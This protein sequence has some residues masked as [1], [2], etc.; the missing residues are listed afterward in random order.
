M[1]AAALVGADGIQ[2]WRGAVDWPAFD[3]GDAMVVAGDGVAKLVLYP[4]APGT[5]PDWRLINRVIYAR[6]A[7]EGTPP[8]GREHWSRP[9][10]PRRSVTWRRAWRCHS[11]MSGP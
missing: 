6:V 2:M 1:E 9:G 8:P 7:E 5:A 10:G 3:G 11:S 4:I